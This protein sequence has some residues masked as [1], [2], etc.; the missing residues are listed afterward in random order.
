MAEQD[1]WGQQ[2]EQ[3][4]NSCSDNNSNNNISDSDNGDS[5]TDGESNTQAVTFNT[6]TSL[7]SNTLTEQQTMKEP[8]TSR[9]DNS[10]SSSNA[11]Q[12]ESSSSVTAQRDAQQRLIVHESRSVSALIQHFDSATIHPSWLLQHTEQCEGKV[13]LPQREPMRQGEHRDNSN[14]HNISNKTGSSSSATAASNALNTPS[15]PQLKLKPTGGIRYRHPSHPALR[16]QL[17]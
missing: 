12:S 2:F 7:L 11:S 9:N 6:A 5:D 8:V 1:G 17:Q 3:L 4:T 14:N 16:M 15:N 10:N 13:E